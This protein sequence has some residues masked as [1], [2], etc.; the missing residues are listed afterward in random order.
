MK[1]SFENSAPK[2]FTPPSINEFQN[3]NPE[4]LRAELMSKVIIPRVEIFL[5]KQNVE[6]SDIISL[7]LAVFVNDGGLI[8]EVK[9][10]IKSNPNNFTQDLEKALQSVTISLRDNSDL[11][12]ENIK[13]MAILE[14][15]DGVEKGFTPTVRIQ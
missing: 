2:Q 3:I 1:N 10:V 13:F 7:D 8:K 9:F 12:A 6:N 4:T 15:K 11:K 14:N 5:T